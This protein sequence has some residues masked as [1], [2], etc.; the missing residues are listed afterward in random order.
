MAL[1]RLLVTVRTTPCT[2]DR[3]MTKSTTVP[4]V[5]RLS[6]RVAL[7]V[8]TALSSNRVAKCAPEPPD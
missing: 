8:V 6:D 7:G 4:V 1:E 5:G 2:A 3:V